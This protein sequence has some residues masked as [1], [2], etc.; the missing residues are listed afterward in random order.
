MFMSTFNT[1]APFVPAVGQT[2]YVANL[3]VSGPNNDHVS[4]EPVFKRVACVGRNLVIFEDGS[5]EYLRSCYPNS[6]AGHAAC[7]AWCEQIA[8][9]QRAFNWPIP[10]PS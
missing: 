6:K 10:K 8:T 4:C 7:V 9:H 5:D 1:P 2:V 3:T